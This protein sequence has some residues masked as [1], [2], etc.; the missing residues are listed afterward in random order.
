[1]IARAY[2]SHSVTVKCVLN[3][4]PADLAQ[5]DVLI[6][7]AS[8]WD[9]GE[10]PYDWQRWWPKV[11]QLDLAGKIV[12]LFGLGDQTGYPDTFC[13][14]IRTLYD[15]VIAHGGTV[16]GGW[17]TEDYEFDQ[18]TAVIDGAFVGLALDEINQP[19]WTQARVEA[20]CQHVLASASLPV[21]VYVA[22]N[23]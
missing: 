16:I 8:T 17:S 23:Q 13:D 7:G 4:A 20:W 10:L 21:A 1:M 6:L 18:S 11:D 22:G 14:A 3:A 9:I 19:E 5:Q 12:A 2:A 15:A